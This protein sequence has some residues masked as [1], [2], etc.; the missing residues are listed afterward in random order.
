MFRVAI[1][2][3]EAQVGAQVATTEVEA[4]CTSQTMPGIPITPRRSTELALHITSAFG[5]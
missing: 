4:V 3:L 1:W 5:K 2:S